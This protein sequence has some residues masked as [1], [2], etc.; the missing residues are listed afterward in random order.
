[1]LML[2]CSPAKTT[3]VLHYYRTWHDLKPPDLLG[4]RYMYISPLIWIADI[5]VGPLVRHESTG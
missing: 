5:P 2:R 4:C 1:M 3:R